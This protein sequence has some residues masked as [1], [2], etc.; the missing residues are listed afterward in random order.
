[1][2]LKLPSRL[3]RLH[4]NLLSIQSYN[5]HTT[6]SHSKDKHTLASSHRSSTPFMVSNLV[7]VHFSHLIQFFS[8]SNVFPLSCHAQTIQ[9]FLAQ[10]L[11]LFSSALLFFLS[12]YV[13]LHT[14]SLE[15]PHFNYN[16]VPYGLSCILLEMFQST[17]QP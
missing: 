9:S 8:L 14:Y 3:L 6:F 1:M 16:Q 17:P 4:Q 7:Y 10:F 5:M 12:P 13:L 15:T 11:Q 2:Q